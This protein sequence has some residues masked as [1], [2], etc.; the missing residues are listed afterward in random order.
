MHIIR[1]KIKL[2]RK[3]LRLAYLLVKEENYYCAHRVL[4]GYPFQQQII[5]AIARI[6]LKAKYGL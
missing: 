6:I 4:D 2:I 1:L 5:T 3:E